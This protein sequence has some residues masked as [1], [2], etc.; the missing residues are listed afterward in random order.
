VI[1]LLL[2]SAWRDQKFLKHL[3][4]SS[5]PPALRLR[6]RL[7]ERFC[8]QEYRVLSPVWPMERRQYDAFATG[9][10]I[11]R[12]FQANAAPVG[13]TVDVD[14]GFGCHENR[15]PTHGYE[16]TGE[17]AMAAFAKSWRRE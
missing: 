11:G 10:V 6:D 7:P 3:A 15:T 9:V 5:P 14:L 1:I 13:T 12:I 16:A 2:Q 4:R 8:E 17:A